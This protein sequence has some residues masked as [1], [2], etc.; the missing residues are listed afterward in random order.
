MS[1]YRDKSFEEL[2]L[3]D[4]LV[5]NN[6]MQCEDNKDMQLQR[7]SEKTAAPKNE[8]KEKD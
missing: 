6:G 8:E 5:G 1:P 2:R 4:Y 3:D 7:K